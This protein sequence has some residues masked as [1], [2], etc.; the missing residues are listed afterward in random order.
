M[1]RVNRL[2]AE[3]A[4]LHRQGAQHEEIFATLRTEIEALS[5]KER[6]NLRSRLRA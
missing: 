4:A 2:F 6:L 1:D 5:A 3:Y